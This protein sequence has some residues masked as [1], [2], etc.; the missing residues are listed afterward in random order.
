MEAKPLLLVV[1]DEAAAAD[2]LRI[3]FEKMGYRV[4]LAES[5]PAACDIA[6]EQAPDVVVTDLLLRGDDSGLVLARRLRDQRPDL[7]IFITS[8]MPEDTVRTAAAGIAGIR[9]VPKPLR[10]SRLK[11]MIDRALGSEGEAAGRD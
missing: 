8:G 9:V 5:S 11:E 3:Y 1:E 4:L 6:A 7:P 10:M 2:M